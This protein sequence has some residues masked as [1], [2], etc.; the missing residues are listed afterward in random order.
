M[1]K[2]LVIASAGGLLLLLVGAAAALY[3]GNRRDVTT[4]SDA[5][6]R[7]YREAIENERRYYFKEA[8]E[9]Y[10]KALE[11]DPQFAEAM[12]GLA[13]MTEGDQGLTLVRR[14]A[15]QRD[16]LTERERMH[17]D[18]QLAARE[19][20]PEDRLKVARAIHE[21]YPDDIR[22]ATML[23][24]HEIQN[25]STER[26][27]QIFSELLAVEPNNAD[28]Y[29]QIGYYYGYRG[30]YEKAIENL[31]KY[32]FMAPDQAN[33]YDSLGEIQAY[34]GRYDEA[35]QNLN[36]ALKLKPDFFAS[37]L[38]L[39]VAYEGK[40]D[41]RKAIESYLKGAEESIEE[42]MKR[43]HLRQA[44][45][46]A[47]HA[48][49]ASTARAV[50]ARIEAMPKD[51][52]AEIRRPAYQAIL[53]LLD[54]KPA[55]AEK[56]IRAIRPKIDAAYAEEAAKEKIGEEAGEKISFDPAWNTLL[57]TALIAQGRSDE[58]IPLCEQLANPPRPFGNF[59]G[60]RWVY[61]GR[62]MLAEL[63][64]RRGDL[65]RAEKL[66]AENKKWNPSWAPTRSSELVVAQL[67]REKVLAAAN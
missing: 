29:N 19:G 3:F 40:G 22:A 10:A 34:S 43:E 4:A 36:Q 32:Q 58:A 12:L 54:G 9:G 61:E 18:L 30:D 41:T 14:A 8:R 38:H 52:W 49:D 6:Y 7:A 17:V 5:A 33:P 59:E 16:R 45:R 1:R 47:F 13:R 65:D 48:R 64:A 42:N 46:A 63:L 60:R 37:Y 24:H 53:L 62:A 25:G 44:L 50:I 55:E 21:R 23:A 66:L 39:G 28:A 20:R 27:L 2:R 15:K 35:I 26:A 11:L 56:I 57:A 51:K 31:R 67:R